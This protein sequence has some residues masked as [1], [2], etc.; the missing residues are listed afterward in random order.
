MKLGEKCGTKQNTKDGERKDKYLDDYHEIIL[1][2][3]SNSL[4]LP[5]A[6]RDRASLLVD[7]PHL[8]LVRVNVHS[9]VTNIVTS[10][11]KPVEGVKVSYQENQLEEKS[12][13]CLY[14]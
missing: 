6:D 8:L 14:Y 5:H 1:C 13:F 9:E 3:D 2:T 11:D 7:L 10:C 4:F 12:V